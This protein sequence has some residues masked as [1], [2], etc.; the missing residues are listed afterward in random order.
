MLII[1]GHGVCKVYFSGAHIASNKKNDYMIYHEPNTED[2]NINCF[3]VDRVLSQWLSQRDCD[4]FTIASDS[5]SK[6]RSNLLL[7]LIDYRVRVQQVIKEAWWVLYDSGHHE[8]DGDAAHS[9]IQKKWTAR[10]RF[11]LFAFF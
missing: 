7:A 9:P 11:L 2:S 10:L 1:V 8:H 6:I 5:S 4:K 3:H